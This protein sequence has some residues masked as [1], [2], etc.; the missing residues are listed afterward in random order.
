MGLRRIKDLYAAGLLTRQ[1]VYTRITELLPSVDVGEVRQLFDSDSRLMAELIDW[2][3]AIAGG[4]TV[5]G[6]E[7]DETLPSSV[8]RREAARLRLELMRGFAPVH[9]KSIAYPP[10]RNERMNFMEVDTDLLGQRSTSAN[11]LR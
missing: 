8:A 1:E 3:R 10:L 5:F 6:G 9:R 11:D 2:L 4:A 7:R